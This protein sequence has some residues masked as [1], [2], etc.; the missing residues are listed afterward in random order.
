[1]AIVACSQISDA[2]IERVRATVEASMDA[3]ESVP[4]FADGEAIA[5]VQTWLANRSFEGSDCLLLHRAIDQNETGAEWTEDVSEGT[6]YVVT[7]TIGNGVRWSWLVTTYEGKAK[8]SAEIWNPATSAWT[9]VPELE[10]RRTQHA[11]VALADGRV[12]VTGGL[13]VGASAE[14]YDPEL[15]TWTVA[16]DMVESRKRHAVALLDDG[17]VLIIGGDGEQ[18]KG[19]LAKTELYAP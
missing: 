2:D 15:D 5:V 9:L 1:M 10:N 13:G 12:L 6:S 8:T 7:H 19:F 11:T 4:S 17:H 3:A 18:G 14:I 16:P